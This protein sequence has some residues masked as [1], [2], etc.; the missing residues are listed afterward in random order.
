MRASATGTATIWILTAGLIGSAAGWFVGETVAWL[1][2]GAVTGAGTA[3]MIPRLVL[4]RIIRR[5]DCWSSL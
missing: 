1:L 4:G 3:A 2:V 5:H